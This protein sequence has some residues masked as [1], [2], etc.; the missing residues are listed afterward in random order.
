MTSYSGKHRKV[1]ASPVSPRPPRHWLSRLW[2][3]SFP[4]RPQPPRD[5]IGGFWDPFRFVSFTE[6]IDIHDRPALRGL[7][8]DLVLPATAF[9]VLF[10]VADWVGD[11][12]YLSD[13]AVL[14]WAAMLG[15]AVLRYLRWRT[16][17]YILTSSRVMLVTGVFRRRA[18]S[19]G[20]GKIT[21]LEYRQNVIERLFGQ[22]DIRILSANE[23][24]PLKELSDLRCPELFYERIVELQ[25]TPSYVTVKEL[26]PDAAPVRTIPE[27]SD[28]TDEFPTVGPPTPKPAGSFHNKARPELPELPADQP[29]ASSQSA[30]PR[31]LR[32]A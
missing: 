31:L 13:L 29:A 6:R 22:A 1:R 12:A 20:L 28:D 11:V 17:H 24:S 3:R 14:A 25:R 23:D 8:T 15:L 10:V 27:D 32:D 19:I 26:Q 7:L 2:F 21:D 30:P 4:P 16:T 5:R 9:A 18:L